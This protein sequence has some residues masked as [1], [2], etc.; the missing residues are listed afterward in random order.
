MKKAFTIIEFVICTSMM[1]LIMGAA[2]SIPF[3]KSKQTNY[4]QSNHDEII[5]SCTDGSQCRI[6]IE[7]PSGRNEFYTLQ[8]IG[9]GAAGSSQKGGA[10][11]EAKIVH[12][13]SLPEGDYIIQLGEGGRYDGGNIN[14]G[15]TAIYRVTD[16][17]N[18]L[19]EFALGGRGSNEIIHQSEISDDN[20]ENTIRAQLQ[21][22]E[23]PSFGAQA[24]NSSCGAGG[25]STANG[26]RGVVII[27]W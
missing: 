16:T 19:L 26:N 20:R 24:T 17:G 14:G 10:A 25:N 1:F 22:G 5:C 2:I 9:G 27:K 6:T 7:N 3:K 15:T 13:P 21:Q 4:V 11:G 23:L 18:E 12:Y 8:L